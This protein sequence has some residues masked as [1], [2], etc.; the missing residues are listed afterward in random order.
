M[1]LATL[2]NRIEGM[3]TAIKLNKSNQ[4]VATGETLSSSTVR[5]Y[6]DGMRL[7][8]ETTGCD[9]SPDFIACLRDTA[10]VYRKLRNRYSK[11]A[12]IKKSFG[13]I[14][15]VAKYIPEFK[16]ALG[17][18]AHAFYRGE[19]ILNIK[20][21]EAAATAAT[22]TQSVIP[23]NT[24]RAKLA[25]IE[26]RFGAVSNKHLEALLQVEL[27]GIRDDLGDIS[28]VA[29]Q[30][31]AASLGAANYY[32]PR[33]RTLVIRKYKTS[34][35]PGY[36]P[37]RFVLPVRTGKLVAESLKRAPRGKLFPALV[38]RRVAKTFQDAG[39]DGVTVNTIRH[40]RITD[41]LNAA[42]GPSEANVTR[43]AEAH[44]HSKAMTLRYYR[45]GPP[46]DD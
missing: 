34:N 9:S 15:S 2:L 3:R 42:G 41:L 30:K 40:S 11:D 24:I 21:A 27:I 39:L 35:V 38:G 22:E 10:T 31:E 7:I 20:S 28:V 8:A 46:A 13:V 5:Q 44:K 17:D 25:D 14:T 26:Q 43:V 6:R 45:G 16:A 18:S 12:S 33:T 4:P 23:I 32:I 36:K 1:T 19:M 29:N 37:Y